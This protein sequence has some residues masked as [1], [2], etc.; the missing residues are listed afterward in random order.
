MAFSF[1]DHALIDSRTLS[2]FIFGVDDATAGLKDGKTLTAQQ[3]A[4]IA[5]CVNAASQAIIR[6]VCS[7]IKAADYCETWD[8]TCADELIP[9]EWPVLEIKTGGVKFS[10]NGD[11]TN[12]RALP[13]LLTY[14]DGHTIMFRNGVETP[15]GRGLVRITYRAGYEDV[16]HDIQVACMLQFQWLYKQLGTGNPMLGISS[17][18]KMQEAMSKDTALAKGGLLSE[19]VGILESY[20]RFEAPHSMMFTR[21]S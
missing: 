1:A 8:G 12:A 10:A 21:V 15:R 6:H 5:L 17:I 13:D 18:S 20:R 4:M 16:P 7:N 14:T 11:F 19:V 2:Q 9:K 3:I